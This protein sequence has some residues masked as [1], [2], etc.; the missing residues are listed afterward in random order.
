MS[1]DLV[2][3]EIVHFGSGIR[4]GCWKFD[5]LPRPGDHAMLDDARFEVMRVEHWGGAAY[6][7]G[8]R[9]Y[10]PRTRIYVAEAVPDWA[11]PQR[12]AAMARF[13]IAT[14]PVERG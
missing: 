1:N 2:K 13:R 10:P 14:H 8:F 11:Q 5:H 12:D 9:A 7:G 4:L 3:A 6:P